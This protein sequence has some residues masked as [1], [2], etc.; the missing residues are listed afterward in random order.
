MRSVPHGENFK[1]NYNKLKGIL[2]H[3]VTLTTPANTS[4]ALR[5]L[6]R[7]AAVPDF[8]ISQSSKSPLIPSIKL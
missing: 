1:L 5:V 4:K 6:A 7:N 8:Y 2:Q 3:S